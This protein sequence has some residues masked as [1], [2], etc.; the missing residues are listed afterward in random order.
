MD[1]IRINPA[2]LID[3][4]IANTG[5]GWHLRR[6][7]DRAHANQ[8]ILAVCRQVRKGFKP[9]AMNCF[10]PEVRRAIWQI[11]ITQHLSNRDL[12]RRVMRGDLS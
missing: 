2:R 11:V 6:M 10:H 12:Y 7:T 3:T 1:T 5:S 4:D 8:S 9:G